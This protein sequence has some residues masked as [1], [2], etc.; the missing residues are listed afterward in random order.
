MMAK[1]IYTFG[2]GK[3]EGNAGMRNLLGGKGANLAEMNLLGMPVPPG[4]TIT[5]DVCTEYTQYG[6][7][8][9]VAD[10]KNEVEEAIA[11]VET[12]TGKKFDDSSNPL[13]VSVRS[14]ARASMPGMMDTVL[15]LGMNDATVATMAEK[16]G[17]PRFAWDS[18]RRFV[19]MYGDVV[20]GMKPKSKTDIDPFEAIMDKVK[21]EKG[22]KFDN[23]LEVEDLKELVVRFKAAVKDYT[24]K[25]F[26][27]SAW[28][29]LW[30]GICAVFDS[31]M[32]ERAILYRRMNQIPEE[33][34]TAVNVQAMV[35][36]NMGDN[37][38]TGVAFSR[39]AATGEN[40]FNGEYLINAQGEDVVAG[41][42]TPQQI[43][44]E[45]SR[46]WAAL[47][48]I[49]E[50]ERA[51]KYPSLEESMP[52]CA[53][54]L[55]AIANKLEGYYKDMQDMEFTIQDGK[56]WMLQTRNGKRTGAAMVRIAMELLREG[57]IDEKEALL[58]MEPQKLDELLHPVF[59]KSDIK[60]AKVMAKGLPASP[61]AAAGQIVF[62]ADDAEAW[63]EK[64]KK[65]V[66]V[67]IETS[68]E[69]LRGMA[70]AQGI[71]TMRGGMTSHAAVV[72]RGM[73]KCCV[74]GAGEIKVDYKAKTVEMNGKVYNEGDWISLNGSTGEVYDG[75]V[76]TR[77]PELDGDF[78]AIMNL[79]AKYTKTLVRTNADSPRDAKQ[80]RHFGA[81][82]IGLCRTE[83]M[84]FEGDRIKAVREMI[85]A[86]DVEGRRAAL[87]KLL[88][89]QR[90][91]FEGIFEAM[92]GYGVTIRL[93]DP[94]LHEFVPHQTATQKELANEMGISLEEVKAKVDALE[95]FNPMLG[96]RGCRLGITYPEITEMQ[97]RAILEAALNCK[98]RGI[99][100][101]PE[102]MVPLVGVLKELQNQADVINTTAAKVFEERG[103]SI[104]YKVGTMIEVPR[105]ALTAN[106]IA[107]VADFFSFGT[108]DLTQMTFG[109]SRDDAPKF[110]KF[111]KE[112]GIVKVDPFEV[113]DQE[114]VGQLVKMGVEKG[115]STNPDLKV[116]ICGEHGGEPSSV[117]FCAKLGMNYVSCSPFRVPIARV[118][119]AQ[120]A[121]ED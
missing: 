76:P 72:A 5:T 94:P 58:R 88:P 90:G 57:M 83:H 45:G 102:I 120:A 85:L 39:D 84:F 22:V 97:T 33:W 116:G 74:S 89:M 62:Q 71:L 86:S 38:A 53:A 70:V 10:I 20:L 4:F 104:H 41:V 60:K 54:E 35:Y 64:K 24:G 36:G 63:A 52:V 51:S 15:N 6:R 107:E 50:E 100:V 61:G 112:N 47:Q 12:L 118:A 44:V 28:E 91:D 81:Q 109:Y 43:T 98:A 111:Y 113:L 77:D 13:L 2:D 103:E 105:A 26:P 49:S 119:A 29:Q 92:D 23:E 79:A 114:G 82:G 101:E 95:E 87:A 67:R 115:R 78:G 75:Q 1:A 21:E 106:K 8:K 16:S 9:V 80:A 11:H 59:D 68:P 65:V 34:G 121:I 31:W 48:G 96:H 17:N 14:G 3:A 18:Y 110:L 32:N 93:L 55:I 25:D 7:D 46:R 73:G 42:R 27:E 99:K 108:N 69:D 117:K 30:G 66:L 37:S 56:L 19:Q 40:I